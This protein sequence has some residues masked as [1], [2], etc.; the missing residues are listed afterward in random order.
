MN[1]ASDILNIVLLLG[2]IQ[3][4]TMTAMVRF[5]TSSRLQSRLFAWLMAVVTLA[6]ANLYLLS[7]PWMQASPF[8]R[9]LPELVPLMFAMAVGP[10]LYFY[11]RAVLDPGFT[12]TRRRRWQF[13]PLVIDMIPYVA[14]WVFIIGALA[15]WLAANPEPWG[16]FIDRWEKYADIPRWA[17][18]SVYVLLARAYL[19]R[20]RPDDTAKN[21]VWR[22]LKQFMNVFLIFQCI[23]F[24][25]LVPY[26]FSSLR[27]AWWDRMGWLPVYLPLV[28]MIYWL[29]LKG[30][31]FT[32][33]EKQ[34]AGKGIALPADTVH[35]TIAR[36][37]MAMED[38][39]L[40]LD[41]AL[42]LSMLAQH[43]D[44]PQKTISA[45]LNQHLRQS[46]S[47]FVNTYRV[48]A[49][50]RKV[51]DDSLSHLTINGIAMEC[52]FSSQATFQRIFKQLAGMTPSEF[53][54]QPQ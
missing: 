40:Y 30:Y 39:R 20:R 7:A 14:A 23:H 4:A 51:N 17:S 3:G 50:K 44:I 27:P 10:L 9:L 15:G 54:K 2:I 36:L 6:C 37:R 42:H 48:E 46:F 8:L 13:A 1:I 41:P 34:A 22:W 25:Y 33:R 49:F 24:V 11:V 19:Y 18:L 28:V 47:E 53:R 16:L 32:L 43:L 29:G 5:A 52:G 26:I 35:A 38:E 45:V 31:V 12:L 21:E